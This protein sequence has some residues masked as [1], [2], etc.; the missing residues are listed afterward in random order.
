[1][2]ATFDLESYMMH[3]MLDQKT[4]ELPFLPP[5]HLPGFLSVHGVMLIICAVVLFVIFGVLYDKKGGAPRGL[6]NVLE[7]FIL[8]IRDQIVKPYLGEE[9]GRKMTPLFCTFF[10]FILFLNLLGLIPLFST[11]TS[12]INVTAGLALIT[13]CFMIIGAFYKNGVKGFFH[14]L[15][16]SGVPVPVLFLLVPIEI[17]GL[18]IKCFALMIRLF[19][20]MLSGHI[21]I[22]ALLGI[23]ILMGAKALPAVILA[24]LVYVL[25]LMVAFLQA[26]IFTLLSAMFMGQLYHPEH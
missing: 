15:I 26:Y 17:A 14:A 7:V 10:F 22:I 4:W 19:A 11:A 13:F 8:F 3:H 23:V 25:E 9:D 24:A 21:V 1:M 5:I 6:T 20:N 2:T 12:N 16:P 18:F